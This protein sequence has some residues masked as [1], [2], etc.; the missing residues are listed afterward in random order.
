MA[1]HIELSS[2][3]AVV[4]L[5]ATVDGL[6][7]FDF[8][9]VFVM[10]SDAQS[11]HVP[12]QSQVAPDT[13]A[14]ALSGV[15]PGAR[16]AS[17]E[18]HDM[19]EQ[20]QRVIFE[21][22]PNAKSDPT[23][24]GP[25][26]TFKLQEYNQSMQDTGSYYGVGSSIFQVKLDEMAPLGY[27]PTR[28]DV[29]KYGSKYYDIQQSTTKLRWRTTL[30]IPCSDKENPG[31]AMC[32][33]NGDKDVV[34]AIHEFAESI[35]RW[36]KASTDTKPDLEAQMQSYYLAIRHWPID[37]HYMPAGPSA[38]RDHFIKAFQTIETVKIRSD[39]DGQSAWE[40][41]CSFAKVRS[42]NKI[43]LGD[44]ST[45]AVHAFL[46][47]HIEFASTSSDY[48]CRPS[49]RN[50]KG[51]DN[52]LLLFDK[53]DQSCSQYTMQNAKAL[54]GSKSCLTQMSKATLLMQKSGSDLYKVRWMVS[55]MDY[56][57]LE[58]TMP[59]DC[60]IT[61]LKTRY[62]AQA[63]LTYE[64]HHAVNTA[65][66]PY[67]D[68]RGSGP[69]GGD[70]AGAGGSGG[71]QSSPEAQSDP[72]SGPSPDDQQSTVK[73]PS[74]DVLWI[75]S[76]AANPKWYSHVKANN[77][78]QKMF[79]SQLDLMPSTKQTVKF[80][81]SVVRGEEES[82]L[83]E[84]IENC[85]AMTSE[86]KLTYVTLKPTVEKIVNQVRTDTAP[87]SVEATTAE[88][89][90]EV[91]EHDEQ[92]KQVE[93][94]LG[95][96]DSDL[97]KA[98][99]HTVDRAAE[100]NKYYNTFVEEQLNDQ[101]VFQLRPLTKPEWIELF[102]NHVFVVNRG[103]NCDWIFDP[104]QD[105][106]P[107]PS[108]RQSIEN[109]TVQADITTAENFLGAAEKVMDHRDKVILSD[110]KHRRNMPQLM[111]LLKV[112]KEEWPVTVTYK[113]II[114][115]DD[116]SN[117]PRVRPRLVENWAY[118]TVKAWKPA[119]GQRDFYTFTD[120]Q[121]DA[122]VQA[123]PLVS[124]DN[125]W[126]PMTVKLAVHGPN[127]IPLP[128]KDLPMDTMV[129]LTSNERHVRV[130]R[131]H[132][133]A[134]GCTRVVTPTIGSGLMLKAMS[135]SRVKGLI[136]C[137]NQAHMNH[138]KAF[139][140]EFFMIEATTN[141]KTVVC[142]YMPRPVV[143]KK[144]G[145]APDI[146]TAV[147]ASDSDDD[148]KPIQPAPRPQTAAEE[149]SPTPAAAVATEATAAA[150]VQPRDGEEDLF[151]SDD[152]DDD[153]ELDVDPL[154][155]L[156]N[157]SNK[158]GAADEEAASEEVGDEPPK[159]KGKGKGRGKGDGTKTEKKK[160]V[161]K[162]KPEGEAEGEGPPKKRTRAKATAKCEQKG[163]GKDVD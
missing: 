120:L 102:Q 91:R 75:K 28:A 145:L 69:D 128:E 42:D 112:A 30:L 51:A 137:K 70:G 135:L 1:L 141:P 39:E 155:A 59:N 162:V 109:A 73:T 94:D 32:R 152:L 47:K 116:D 96:R 147:D 90:L 134:T 11:H 103:Q 35:R 136:L 133:K 139:M 79:G 16:D 143:L 71:L 14:K 77:D 104:S 132:F 74:V 142:D 34:A 66:L 53:V 10:A 107:A 80:F 81:E 83:K 58:K 43:L 49:D 159:K 101:F 57:M 144:L 99:H 15:V 92:R 108:E 48:A 54:H 29:V 148:Q 55:Y 60:S 25:Y 5:L 86:Q 113:Q 151:G 150:E 17:Q 7:L 100:V 9:C 19:L 18:L 61:E 117:Q 72:T 127:S 88:A 115:D 44:A 31:S 45:T 56:R 33:L 140:K 63:L 122:I 161:K 26:R 62:I 105:K 36:H 37:Y 160:R 78:A 89:T 24:A 158:D 114:S 82:M 154:A 153:E 146:G 12:D 4:R 65:I 125:I 95:K 131:E 98:M 21:A 121:S 124:A 67:H 52:A 118:M 123:D 130:W 76:C 138:L 8:A 85:K 119:R 46:A 38:Q 2:N 22:F 13:F 157:A 23:T 6:I 156:F 3:T 126:V 68:A 111:K 106:E 163:P 41:A 149:V 93:A 40:T 27:H 87:P 84:M 50:S 20:D 64:L 110:A 97:S 129:P